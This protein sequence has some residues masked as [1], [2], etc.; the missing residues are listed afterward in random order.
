M[1]SVCRMS[2]FFRPRYDRGNSFD[3]VLR[4]HFQG[5]APIASTDAGRRID[6]WISECWLTGPMRR[7]ADHRGHSRRAEVG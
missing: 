5:G 3:A 7:V 2:I 4:H 6:T 1:G